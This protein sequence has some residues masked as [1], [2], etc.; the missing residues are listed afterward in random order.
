MRSLACLL[1]LTATAQAEQQ[2]QPQDAGLPKLT[3]RQAIE[4]AL[5]DNPRVLDQVEELER[6]RAQTQQTRSAA[7]PTLIGNAAYTRYSYAISLPTGTGTNDVVQKSDAVNANITATLPL[8]APK[9]WVRWS[10]ARSTERL[11]ALNVGDIKRQVAVTV[12]SAYL[13]ILARRREAE[14]DERARDTAKVHADYTHTRLTGGMGSRLDD[15]RAQQE[16]Q[17]DEQLVVSARLALERA[18]ETLGVLVAADRPVDAGEEPELMTID[19]AQAQADAPKLRVDLLALDARKVLARKIVREDWADYLPTLAATFAPTY[20]YPATTFTAPTWSWEFQLVLSVPF[21]DGGLRYGLA[22]ERKALVREATID[23]EATLRQ[24][25]SDLR[26]GDSAVRKTEEAMARA[27]AAAQLAHEAVKIADLAYHAGATTNLELIDAERR[28]R[29]ADTA[30]NIAED[31]SR[32]ARLD[33]LFAAGRL[34]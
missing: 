29:D 5:H 22:R 24:A 16:L 3:L 20:I 2:A 17:S 30:A 33:V 9:A 27:R 23:Q 18:Q 25:R 21:Y 11:N 26:V 12:S 4:R 1:L 10:Q 14:L 6:A 19:P 8:L 31:A 15:V 34:P 28:A 13:A 32:Q 7:L